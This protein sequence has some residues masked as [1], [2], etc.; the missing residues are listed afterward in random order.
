M[1]RARDELDLDDFT[2]Y[3]MVRYERPPPPFCPEC[4]AGLCRCDDT[5]PPSEAIL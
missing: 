2:D 1:T 5:A 3:G 4:R